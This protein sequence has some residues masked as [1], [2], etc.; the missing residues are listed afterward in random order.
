MK[1][2]RILAV[3]LSAV[4]VAG[5]F[6][7]C[8]SNSKYNDIE[9][10]ST[11][12]VTEVLTD[13]NGEAVTNENG[14]VQTVTVTQNANK[15]NSS[16]SNNS[17]GTTQAGNTNA[18]SSSEKTT[19]TTTKKENPTV[20]PEETPT[21][22]TDIT[23]SVLMPFFSSAD[24]HKYDIVVKIDN[25]D[26]DV[27]TYSDIVGCKGQTVDI[28]IPKKFSGKDATVS[29][30]MQGKNYSVQTKLDDGVE[31]KLQTMIIVDGID[32]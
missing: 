31:I 14:E 18:P 26:K 6:A 19:V 23:M 4:I 22:K 7:A 16:N 3:I 1:S 11:E 20:A 30:N 21:K 2:K 28:V 9:V 29:V 8:S 17:T 32:D 12:I 10:G 24:A 5:A 27:L 13:A 15:P 25:K